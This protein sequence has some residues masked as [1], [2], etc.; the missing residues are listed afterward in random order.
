[1][2]DEA[3]IERAV[4]KVLERK[5]DPLFVER[6][7]HF[8]DHLKISKLSIADVLFLVELNKLFSDIKSTSLKAIVKIVVPA[9]LGLLALGLG[10]LIW[11]KTNLFKFFS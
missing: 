9:T 7:R 11:T 3:A 2:C 1:M 5:M 4:T 10:A 6:E 8:K